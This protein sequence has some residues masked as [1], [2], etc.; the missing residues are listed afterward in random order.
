MMRKRLKT[1]MF[2][3]MK[4]MPTVRWLTVR[5]YVRVT[6]RHFRFCV[7]RLILIAYNLWESLTQTIMYGIA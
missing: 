4:T 1:M 2:R 7:I 5:Q 3:T 6:Q